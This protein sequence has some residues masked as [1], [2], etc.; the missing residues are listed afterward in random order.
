MRT[1]VLGTLAL[2]LGAGCFH[3]G[4]LRPR[5]DTVQLSEEGSY[6][7]AE[8]HGVKLVAYGASWKGTPRDVERHLNLVQVRLENHSGRPLSVRYELF[9]LVGEERHT[10]LELSD[11]RKAVSARALGL[12]RAPEKYGHHLAPRRDLVASKP[13]HLPDM[14]L[15]PYNG[16]P[17]H[18]AALCHS[19]GTEDAVQR[20]PSPDMVRL[21]LREGPLENSRVREGF[22]YFEEAR[23]VER[24]AA[25]LARLLDA[26]TGEEFGTLAIPFEVY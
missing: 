1:L 15:N 18:H 23:G 13:Q 24:Q 2:L 4:R 7:I 16:T 10:A 26:R 11:L 25:L 19:C 17:E 5:A 6:A 21:A 22:L 8:A 20:I 9:E 12:M 14:I 3:H